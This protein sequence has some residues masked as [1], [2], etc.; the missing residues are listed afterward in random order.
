MSAQGAPE[1]GDA[2]AGPPAPPGRPARRPRDRVGV[3]LREARQARGLSLRE[4]GERLGISA[5]LISQIENGRAN[6]SVS[7]LYALVTELD[8]SLDDLLFEE[9]R[10]GAARPG[11]GRSSRAERMIQPRE[12]RRSIRL[13]SGVTWERLT[14]TSEP[15]TDFLHV[16]YEVGGSSSVDGFQR[17]DGHEWGYVLEGTLVVRIGFEE[18]ILHPG[19]AISFDSTTP[20]RLSNVGDVPVRAIW[21]VAGRAPAGPP[22]R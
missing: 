12:G 4:L 16:T 9:R 20:H 5:S 7:T 8:V 6:P 10:P 22:H 18:L 21:F 3:R 11:E 17:H 19:D 2:A 1:D 14:P 13:A 15:D